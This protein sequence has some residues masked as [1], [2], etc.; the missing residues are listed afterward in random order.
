[1]IMIKPEQ[2]TDILKT[3]HTDKTQQ[4]TEQYKEKLEA[5]GKYLETEGFKYEANMTAR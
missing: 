5:G 2:Y 1:M 4:H 3:R